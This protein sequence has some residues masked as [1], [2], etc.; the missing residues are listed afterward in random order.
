MGH[1]EQYSKTGHCQCKVHKPN[2]ILSFHRNKQRSNATDNTQTAGIC[3]IRHHTQ[4]AT[5]GSLKKLKF[6]HKFCGLLLALRNLAAVKH[7]RTYKVATAVGEYLP[8]ITVLGDAAWIQE[9]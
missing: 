6:K 2:S 7:L 9:M 1:D 8:L 4:V 3:R 5:S